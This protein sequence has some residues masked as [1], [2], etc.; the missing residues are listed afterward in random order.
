MQTSRV[1]SSATVFVLIFL[2]ASTR[3][4]AV[5]IWECCLSKSTPPESEITLSQ[6]VRMSRDPDPEVRMQ[7][8]GF[9]YNLVLQGDATS[10][11]AAERLACLRYDRE[12][13]DITPETI[14]LMQK[15]AASGWPTAQIA[16]SF[17][18][19][20]GLGVSKDEAE[21]ERLL[22]YSPPAS[23]P[24]FFCYDTEPGR[25]PPGRKCDPWVPGHPLPSARFP[26]CPRMTNKP[27]Y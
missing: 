26:Q 18:Y 7:A 22:K 13:E 27:Q 19:R 15:A 3:V 17:M 20:T 12:Q 2:G 1:L 6:L 14:A 9:L 24:T 25:V 10:G 4:G 21:A 5:E 11:T 23:W 8:E 16:L